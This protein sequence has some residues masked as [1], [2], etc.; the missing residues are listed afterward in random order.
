MVPPTSSLQIVAFESISRPLAASAS[1][2]D[3]TRRR[4]LNGPTIADG[5]GPARP[6]GD[7]RGP[8]ITILQL[9]AYHR[10][11]FSGTVL[12][13]ELGHGGMGTWGHCGDPPVSTMYLLTWVPAWM[14]TNWQVETLLTINPAMMLFILWISYIDIP[15]TFD[16]IEDE[17]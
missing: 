8:E 14:C 12:A 6:V 7:S 1:M 17:F 9:P 10:I 4:C 11:A 15:T 3:L 5:D 16:N 2:A 13:E